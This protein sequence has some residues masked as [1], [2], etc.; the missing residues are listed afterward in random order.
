MREDEKAAHQQASTDQQDDRQRHFADHQ[1]RTQ[2][3][4]TNISLD[5]F[6]AA[7]EP[8]LQIAAHDMKSRSKTT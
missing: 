3:A 6:A 4:M 1:A 5:I 8:R 2:F 7:S